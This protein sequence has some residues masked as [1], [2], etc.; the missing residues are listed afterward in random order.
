MNVLAEVI[1]TLD[2]VLSLGGRGLRFNADT[3]LLGAL[4]ELDSM[5]V[6]ALV[7]AL[8]DSLGVVFEDDDIS[9]ET[10]RTVGDLVRL[11]S[12]RLGVA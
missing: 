6:V 12:D 8:Q 10:F 9:G 4:P 1:R 7:T 2:E 5:A 3:A 11:V